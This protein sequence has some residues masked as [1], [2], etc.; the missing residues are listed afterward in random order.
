MKIRSSLCDDGITITTI[1]AKDEQSNPRNPYGKAEL[2]IS[3]IIDS[4]GKAVHITT[5]DIC[6]ERY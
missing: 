4:Q 3:I 2:N 6:N 1:S 5:Y